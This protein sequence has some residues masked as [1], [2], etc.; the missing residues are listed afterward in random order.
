MKVKVLEAFALGVPVV[1]TAEGVEGIPAEDGVHAGVC[2]DD[3]GLAARA[4]A[5]LLD[6]ARQN[7]QRAA[8]RALVERHCGP[9]ATL[10]AVERLHAAV[11]GTGP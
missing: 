10:D 3:E 9:G 2:E 7:R 11:A 4:V 1:T 8:A 5:L 6:P